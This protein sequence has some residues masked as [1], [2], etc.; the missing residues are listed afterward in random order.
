MSNQT[1]ETNK[2]FPGYPHHPASEDI[3]HNEKKVPMNNDTKG[4][5]QENTPVE[6]TENDINADDLAALEQEDQNIVAARLDN[7]DDDGM[8]LNEQTNNKSL[9]ADLDVPGAE[10]DDADE[11]IG[12]EDDENNYYSLGDNGDTDR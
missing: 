3:T 12:E 9:G 6:N 5:E 2:D 1:E 7:T 10:Q 4:N 11:A 8:P